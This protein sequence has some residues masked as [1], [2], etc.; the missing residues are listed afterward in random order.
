MSY[1]KLVAGLGMF[2]SLIA[3]PALADSGDVTVKVA[4][5]RTKLVDKGTTAV[6]GVVDPAAGYATNDTF[7]GTVTLG[8]DLTSFAT[9]EASVTTP[10]TTMNLP[11]GSLAGSPNLGDDTFIVAT[12]GVTL[13]PLRDS[14]ISPY[15]GGGITAQIT[16]QER[17]ALA[18]N[19]QI[20]NAH[21]PYINAGVDF[22]I[23][24]GW[25][26]FFDVRKSFYTA[27]GSGEIPANATATVWVP[28]RARARLDPL[29]IQAG[30]L[31]RFGGSSDSGN[32][33][34]IGQDDNKW[35]LRMGATMLTLADKADISVGG[36]ALPGTEL[37]TNEHFTPAFQI[38]RFLTQNIAVSAT[39]GVPPTIDIYGGGSLALL[40]KLG[41]TTYG[42]TAF[43]LQ[44]HPLRSG[45][46]RPYVGIGA[47]YMIVFK[48]TGGAFEGLQI[49]DDLAPAFEAG[50][51]LMATNNWGIFV[52][53]KKAFLRPTAF[54]SFGGNAVV[55][56]TQLDPWVFSS[57]VSL[58]F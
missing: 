26:L 33:A 4:A 55:A 8:Y 6:N 51:D 21:G 36:A 9:I 52:D 13:H 28:V 18:R 40:P 19:L 39:L 56:K 2:A 37:R 17:D 27:N 49:S 44:Y 29:T 54:G 25:G 20:G 34:P 1:R 14:T 5:S 53:V 3:A 43:T 12:A 47:S 32:S 41:R 58:R 50:A 57:G 11:A 48:A 46:I 45:R 42:P 35:M 10:Q 22:N 38:G 15:I 30:A 7:H 16:T 24:Q 31:V 23:G